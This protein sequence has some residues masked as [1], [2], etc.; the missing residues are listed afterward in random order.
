MPSPTHKTRALMLFFVLHSTLSWAQA[1]KDSLLNVL[2]TQGPSDS[3][4]C[5][6]VWSYVFNQ[7]DSAIYLGKQGLSWAAKHQSEKY[8][9]PLYNR[10]GV[11]YDIKSMPDSA[12]YWY[13]QALH[14][15]QQRENRKTEAG[16]LNNMGLIYWNL[17]NLDRAID[18]YIQAA[19]IFEEVGNERG[20]GSTYNNIALILHEDQ[21]S[22]KSLSY[23]RKALQVRKKANDKYGI[24]ASYVNMAQIFLFAQPPNIDSAAYYLGLSI[25]L[26]TELNDQYGLARA[27]HNLADVHLERKEFNKAL[28]NYYR[29]LAIQKALGNSE[30]YA[31]TY[32]NMAGVYQVQ[33]QHKVTVAYLDSAQ[34]IAEKQKDRP[35]LWKVYWTKAKTLG[36]L[37]RFEEAHAYWLAYQTLKD[38]LVNAQ[39]STKVEELETK[40]RTAQ[41]ATEL[42]EKKAAL[43]QANLA[44]ENRTK[45]LVVLLSGL[46]ILI[47]LGFALLQRKKRQHQ[48]EKDLAIIQE[49]ERGLRAM[50]EATEE[51]RK[52]IAKDLHDGVV[53]TLTGLSLRLQKGFSLLNNVSEE[54]KQRYTQSQAIL[55]ESI[56][57]I[58]HISHQMMPRAL[59]EMGLIP[60][61]EDMLEKSLGNTSM[62]Y[63]FEHHNVKGKRFQESVEISLFRISQELINNIIKHAGAKA[64]SIQL[65]QTKS[66]LVLVIED[67]GKGF[68]V[69]EIHATNGIGLMNI[70]SRAKAINGEVHYE[71]SPKQGTVATI[72]IPTT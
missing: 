40:Y 12:L 61:M 47:V 5:E 22:G 54:Q 55:D 42:S 3:L 11:A 36:K 6:L 38:S 33:D 28:E 63:E 13:K 26:K 50:I 70:T 56:A 49:R 43:A 19:E 25:P 51:E 14:S 72:R 7:P 9:A 48:H 59:A 64:V 71:P 29:A 44:V 4:Y 66:H 45:W 67:N 17:G 2:H 18:L 37:K 10:I 65:L 35:L 32:Y 8:V 15:S 21:Q 16:V 20:L 34:T 39:R 62:S 30:G 69:Q 58:R 53:Q 52:R 24:A 68:Q 41:Q 57:E 1:K 46:G 60:A 23:H 27:Y 31:S